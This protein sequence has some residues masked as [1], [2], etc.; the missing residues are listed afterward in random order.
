MSGQKARQRVG[1]VG[2]AD[3]QAARTAGK[4]RASGW[5]GM[6]GANWQYMGNGRA[7]ASGMSRPTVNGVWQGSQAEDE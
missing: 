3:Q 7:V 6:A 4:T 5:H 2:N 1:V